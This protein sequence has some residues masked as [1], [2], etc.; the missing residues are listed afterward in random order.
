MLKLVS[1]THTQLCLW[2]FVIQG[3]YLAV[4]H[5]ILLHISLSVSLLNLCH[6]YMSQSPFLN[7]LQSQ[8]AL[9]FSNSHQASPAT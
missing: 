5:F 8:P 6:S 3:I 4:Y 1:H 7:S 2:D 9:E